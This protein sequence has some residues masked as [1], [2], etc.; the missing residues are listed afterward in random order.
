VTLEDMIEE[1]GSQ[2]AVARQ[3]NVD[4]SLINRYVG[5]FPSINLIKL[6]ACFYGVS[7]TDVI[8]AYEK[9]GLI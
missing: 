4:R 5:S 6:I 9:K 3:L 1:L 2:A 8:N 7:V